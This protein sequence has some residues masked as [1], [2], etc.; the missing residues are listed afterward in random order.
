MSSATKKK[1][2]KLFQLSP[3][4]K[5]DPVMLVKAVSRLPKVGR[6]D[7]AVVREDMENAEI[8]FHNVFSGLWR[9]PSLCAAN[10]TWLSKRIAAFKVPVGEDFFDKAEFQLRHVPE[11]WLAGWITLHTK[12]TKEDLDKASDY[13]PEA[14]Y[15]IVSRMTRMPLGCSV[16]AE[17]RRKA[18]C[19]GFLEELWI[20]FGSLWKASDASMLMDNTG[21]MKEETGEYVSVW[22][23]ARVERLTHVPTEVTVDIDGCFIINENFALKDNYS[24]LLA[25][26]TYHKVQYRCCD[27]FDKAKSEGPHSIDEVKVGSKVYRASLDLAVQQVANYKVVVPT[28]AS[29]GAAKKLGS[30]TILDAKN[31]EQTLKARVVINKR[32][33]ELDNKR[34]P[35]LTKPS[36]S[37]PS[38]GAPTAG[39]PKAGA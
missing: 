24:P 27:Q 4:E 5:Q 8:S 3:E 39:A 9:Y 25:T 2:M 7:N 19:A 35:K 38:A 37:A 21:A 26:F 33:S 14:P 23:K 28:V 32:K 18:I 20:K 6:Y 11:L 22:G 1:S 34:A 36:S 15:R 13:D 16:P 12:L 31:A 30:K 29:T 17:C 10:Q